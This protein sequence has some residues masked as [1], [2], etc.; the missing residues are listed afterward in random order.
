MKL[1]GILGNLS[2]L[3]MYIC[4]KRRAA[5]DGQLTDM[6]MWKY[7]H[8]AICKTH[9]GS[10]SQTKVLTLFRTTHSQCEHWHNSCYIA[11]TLTQSKAVFMMQKGQTLKSNTS[12][13]YLSR[14]GPCPIQHEPL[15]GT[16][17]LQSSLGPALV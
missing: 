11:A 13:P 15:Q 5:V 2:I 1:I 10:I 12:S 16:A 8:A 14:S 7:A 9:V 4:P 3:S 6:Y 17:D